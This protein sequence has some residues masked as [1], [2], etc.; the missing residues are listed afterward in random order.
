MIL[1]YVH[2]HTRKFPLRPNFDGSINGCRLV[3]AM[4]WHCTPLSLH[5]NDENKALPPAF[6]NKIKL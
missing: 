4:H 2:I 5:V 1:F 6:N 3:T